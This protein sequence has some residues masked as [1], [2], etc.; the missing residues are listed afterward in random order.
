MKKIFVIL[1]FG[2]LL[3][4][5]GDTKHDVNSDA[6]KNPATA[7]SPV[8]NGDLPVMVFERG[9]KYDFGHAQSGEI[10]VN[11]FYFKNEGKSD[12]IISDVSTSCGCTVSEYPSKPVKAGEEATIT[13]TFN[14]KGRK[15]H[16]TKRATVLTNC[17][18]NRVVLTLTADLEKTDKK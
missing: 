6:V 11:T 3:F 8:D 17:K 15:G 5:C 10:L 18:P 12:L 9:T 16:Q 1:L 2:S 7:D 14:T 13:L 4:S